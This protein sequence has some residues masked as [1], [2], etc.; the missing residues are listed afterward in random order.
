MTLLQDNV[1][2]VE[3][4]S[5]Y[6]RVVFNDNASDQTDDIS[7]PATGMLYNDDTKQWTAY[8]TS[9]PI[10][11]PTDPVSGKYVILNCSACNKGDE[12]WY[13]WTWEGNEEGEWIGA[14]DYSSPSA[15]RYESDKLKS[16]IIFVR[17]NPDG[18]PSWGSKWNQTGNLTFT[19]GKTYTITGWG[20]DYLEVQ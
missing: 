15:M 20:G 19:N 17:M 7:I 13:I 9:Q 16:N 6:D 8:G 14:T 2:Y 3:L 5:G 1:W 11:Q 12:C 18:A 4:P 10:T